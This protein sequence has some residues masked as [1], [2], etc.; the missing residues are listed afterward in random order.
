[1]QDGNSNRLRE[2]AQTLRLLYIPQAVG[3]HKVLQIAENENG[4]A[5]VCCGKRGQIGHAAGKI[6]GNNVKMPCKKGNQR[7]GIGVPRQQKPRTGCGG[8]RVGISQLYRDDAMRSVQKGAVLV[9]CRQVRLVYKTGEQRLLLA[10]CYG[11][12]GVSG[13]PRRFP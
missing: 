2:L 11:A 4:S 1:M 5:V 8:K 10:V 9:P 7:T 12:D 13:I 3:G 6:H